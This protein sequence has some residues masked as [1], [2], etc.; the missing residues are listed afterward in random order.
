MCDD[1]GQRQDSSRTRAVS[2]TGVAFL[3]KPPVPLT[4]DID[5]PEHGYT[6]SIT[7]DDSL[8]YGGPGLC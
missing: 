4:Y 1:R 8:R 5:D 3:D 7:G 6:V 2:I